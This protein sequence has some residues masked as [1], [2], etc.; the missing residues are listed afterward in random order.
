M[1]PYHG[2]RKTRDENY[3]RL[4]VPT[5]FKKSN[6]QLV[7]NHRFSKIW[8]YVHSDSRIGK[9]KFKLKLTDGPIWIGTFEA[10][11]VLENNTR[12]EDETFWNTAMHCRAILANLS[13]NLLY[14]PI[15]ILLKMNNSQFLV[16]RQFFVGFQYLTNFN[17]KLRRGDYFRKWIAPT[18]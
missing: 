16:Y 1:V 15:P 5:I 6:L 8:N 18:S 7:A 2:I 9:S 13:L 11:C 10:R 4:S 17:R 14:S 12:C 3:W